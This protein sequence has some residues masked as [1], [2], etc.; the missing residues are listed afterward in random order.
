M[1]SLDVHSPLLHGNTSQGSEP[2][3]EQRPRFHGFVKT[4]DTCGNECLGEAAR[5]ARQHERKRVGAVNRLKQVPQRPEGARAQRTA[6][7]LASLIRRAPIVNGSF[8]C[9]LPS[10]TGLSAQVCCTCLMRTMA[11][12]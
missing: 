2:R 12:M 8:P 4:A 3:I 9:I 7:L 11:A 1:T 5:D 10:S 6:P